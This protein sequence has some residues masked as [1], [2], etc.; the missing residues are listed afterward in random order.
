[1]SRSSA[2]FFSLLASC[3]C[4]SACSS[5][6]NGPDF[7]SADPENIEEWQVEGKMVVKDA[8]KRTEVFFNYLSLSGEY[9]LQI[10]DTASGKPQSRIRGSIASN[11]QVISVS[12]DSRTPGDLS[13]DEL[14]DAI[15]IK[16]LNYWLRGL[17]SSGDAKLELGKNELVSK[18]EDD[19]WDI[20]YKDHMIIDRFA[21][22]EKITLSK[23]DKKIRIDL[24]R[25]DTGYLSGPCPED[26]YEGKT[27]SGDLSDNAKGYRSVP[28][29]VPK[30]GSAPLPRWI[31]R[32]GFCK[33]LFKVHGGIPDPKVGLYGPDSMMWKLSG[34][35]TATGTVPG[36]ALML[37]FTHPW[38]SKAIY[39]HSMTYD[40]F[41]ERFR[42]TAIG[43]GTIMYGSMPQA[44]G[45]ANKLHKTHSEI[46]GTMDTSEGPFKRGSE[47]RANEV[48][49]MM[50]IWASTFERLA[51]VYEKY[52]GS[53]TPREKE[54][55]YEESKLF[56][57]LMGIPEDALPKN[58]T[59]FIAYNKAMWTSKQLTLSDDGKDLSKVLLKAPRIWLIPTYW[60][61]RTL[62]IADLPPKIR[63][64]FGLKYG[65]VRKFNA[66]W[67]GLGVKI[68]GK[69]TPDTFS[70][71]PVYHEAQ[72]R[73]SGKR[74]GPYQRTLLKRALRIE[75]MVN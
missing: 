6:K 28:E 17:P 60:F 9:E 27:F 62:T 30:D 65:L 64:D 70:H 54:K 7:V 43:F 66:T 2:L 47:Y 58:W 22:P 16:H 23:Q 42:R 14:K 49:V 33:Q 61:V 5:M 44:M 11:E 1:M 45:M 15:P 57:M 25:G 12:K 8:G 34:P 40:D 3:W 36:P 46:E 69:V 35:F 31:G 19:G 56:A 53:L 24:V 39:D 52:E 75:R 71:I 13:V 51:Y 59:Q 26:F 21:L 20:N 37:Q 72:A 50:W 32:E 68:A 41:I 74:V 55:F 29:L 4:L 67:M 73:L 38:L 48:H 10:K 18:I 63:E